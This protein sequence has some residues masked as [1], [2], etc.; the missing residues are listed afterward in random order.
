MGIGL[1]WT[2]YGYNWTGRK[3]FIN[4]EFMPR[5]VGMAG[6]MRVVYVMLLGLQLSVGWR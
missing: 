2:S 4:A 6:R 5:I 1:N 3:W